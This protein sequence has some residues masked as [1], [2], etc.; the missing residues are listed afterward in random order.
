MSIHYNQIGYNSKLP[1]KAIITGKGSNCMILNERDMG[2]WSQ[3]ADE[4]IDFVLSEPIYDEASG[5]TVRVLDFSAASKPGRYFIFADGEQVT[6]EIKEKPYHELNNAL[7]K[8]F[9]YQRC[10]CELQEKHAGHYHH[11]VC[12]LGKAP[13]QRQRRD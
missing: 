2:A 8:G 13:C 1:K 7:L 12:H 10:G 9:Y 5:D 11:A 3:Q 4:K 6:V